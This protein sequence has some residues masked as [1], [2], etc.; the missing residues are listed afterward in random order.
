MKASKS[1]GELRTGAYARTKQQAR[2]RTIEHVL[3]TLEEDMATV[4]APSL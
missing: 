4:A 3:A 2:R 1:L